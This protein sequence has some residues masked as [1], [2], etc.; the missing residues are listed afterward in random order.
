M[1]CV[2]AELARIVFK[3]K[4]ISL[5]S[6]HLWNVPLLA[7]YPRNARIP[8]SPETQIAALTPGLAVENT[9]RCRRVTRQQFQRLR[10]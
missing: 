1:D 8:Y 3:T 9:E 7:G 4:I 2:A 10:T 6:R 5:R